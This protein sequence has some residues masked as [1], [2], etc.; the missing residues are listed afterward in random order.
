[1]SDTVI[2]HLW[3]EG[4]AVPSL[5]APAYHSGLM[6]PAQPI[7]AD[8]SGLSCTTLVRPPRRSILQALAVPFLALRRGG[9]W[10]ARAARAPWRRRNRR[11]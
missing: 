10:L 8:D 6:H 3:R 11:P 7:V 1:V 5:A 9:L 2:C 4:P